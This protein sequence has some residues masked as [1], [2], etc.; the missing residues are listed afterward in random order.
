MTCAGGREFPPALRISACA[1]R[2]RTR[3]FG[4][5]EPHGSASVPLHVPRGGDKKKTIA[6]E[7]GV[8]R[9]L[10]E[11]VQKGAGID[12]RYTLILFEG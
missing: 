2:A 12:D 11:Q 9:C 1:G 7:S 6:R 3:A 4:R 10:L 5:R 8:L